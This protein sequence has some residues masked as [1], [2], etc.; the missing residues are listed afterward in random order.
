MLFLVYLLLQVLAVVAIS[1]VRW[2]DSISYDQL[3]LTGADLRL[4]T[5]PLL[6]WIL[7]SDAL[8]VWAQ[9]LLAAIA[10]WALATTAAALIRDRWVRIGLRLVL[11]GLGLVS[12][13]V[14]WNT[15]I[16][17]ESIAISLT[18]LLVAALIRFRERLDVGTA[19]LLLVV[20]LFWTFA[21]QP[22]VLMCALI[23]LAFVIA[24][25]RSR[26]HRSVCALVAVGAIAISLAGAVE[27]HRNQTISRRNTGAVL[28]MTILPNE[29]WTRWFI[30]QGMPYSPEIARYAGVR[31]SYQK[32]D[33]TYAEWVAWI[34]AHGTSTYATFMLTHLGYTL[35]K[36]LPFFL[37]ETPSDTRPSGGALQPNAT[38]SMLSPIVAYGRSRFVLPSVVDQTLF[39]QGK[40]GVLVLLTLGSV[41]LVVVG[42]RRT[43][44]DRR[45]L[46]PVL[47]ALS[48]IP[49]GYLTWLAG[50]DAVGELDRLS[51]I[52]AVCA[53]IGLWIT[54]AVA[55]DAVLGSRAAA[56]AGAPT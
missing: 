42:W 44:P 56:K 17:S 18:A 38:P 15:T 39:D 33:R 45:L 53:R 8:R 19:A 11:L 7:S 35:V 41:A 51:M 4:P 24:T 31:F 46:V 26:S 12:A 22:H 37:G 3:S 55:L 16:L 52:A 43:G 34:N 49:Q 40:V 23:A 10:W 30:G 20:L 5:V 47:V 13:I 28:Q 48:A 29:A 25:L 21:R 14:N 54:F 32:H 1:P 27:L 6:Y 50:G 36:P 9:V 2:P